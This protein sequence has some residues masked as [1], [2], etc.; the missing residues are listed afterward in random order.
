MSQ[1]ATLS[2]RREIKHFLKV[3]SMFW[4]FFLVHN[5][6][7]SINDL[8]MPSLCLVCLFGKG[9]WVKNGGL[10]HLK[11][12]SLPGNWMRLFSTSV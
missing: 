11:R 3:A 7:Y 12:I 2:V 5:L 4:S 6:L 1:M 8:L 9:C 10:A